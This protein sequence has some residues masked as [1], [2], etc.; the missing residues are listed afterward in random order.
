MY[1]KDLADELIQRGAQIGGKDAGATLVSR[2]TT[3]ERKRF[4]RPTSKG[5]Y[6]LQE[7]Y[8]EVRQSVGARRR[9]K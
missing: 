8:P 1:Y 3:D 9:R 7:D 4:L 2:M 6:A 5:F